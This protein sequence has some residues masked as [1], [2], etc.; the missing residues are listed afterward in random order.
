M[1]I[2]NTC[3]KSGELNRIIRLQM[4]LR[5]CTIVSSNQKDSMIIE[6]AILAGFPFDKSIEM[7]LLYFYIIVQLTKFL[8]RQIKNA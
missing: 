4:D 1:A 7:L 3:L 6:S 2:S 5:K 8:Q